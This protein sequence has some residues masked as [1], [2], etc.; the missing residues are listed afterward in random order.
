MS[1]IRF[2]KFIFLPYISEIYFL[3]F[4]DNII[5]ITN[6]YKTGNLLLND[7]NLRKLFTIKDLVAKIKENKHLLWDV[8]DFDFSHQ[9]FPNTLVDL[10]SIR[11]RNK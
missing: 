7:N 10:R 4:L 5:D 6:N 1:Q 9:I 3:F 8:L 2:I 11:S